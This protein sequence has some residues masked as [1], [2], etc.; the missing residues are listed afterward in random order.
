MCPYHFF[1]SQCNNWEISVDTATAWKQQCKREGITIWSRPQWRGAKSPNIQSK[2][3]KSRLKTR[4]S[5]VRCYWGSFIRDA[6]YKHKEEKREM[7]GDRM[8]DIQ[9]KTDT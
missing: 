5:S 1:C 7:C 9:T 4:A 3:S 8:T 6:Y 2:M